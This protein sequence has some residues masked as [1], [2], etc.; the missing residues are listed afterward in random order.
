VGTGRF[1]AIWLAA[2]AMLWGAGE[3]AGARACAGC[4][5]EQ[6][7]KQARSRHARALRPIL[8]TR[9]PELFR[10][11]GETGGTALKYRPVETGVL[12]TA[13][14]GGE[15]AAALL[16]WAFGAGAQGFTPVGRAGKIYFEH[17][18][19]YYTAPGRRAL[20]LGH[21]TEP[22]PSA[23]AALGMIQTPETIYRCFNCHATG[24][25]R[26]SDRP[27]LSSMQPGVGCERCH[28]PGGEHIAAVRAG[29][30]AQIFRTL[31]NPGRFPARAVVEI[32][33]E[34]HRL[35][36]PGG[37][38]AAPEAEDPVSVRFAPI[39]FSQSKCFRAGKNFSCL[40]CHD[41]HADARRD[42]SFYTSKCLG[43]HGDAPASSACRRA[44][45]QDCLPCHMRRSSPAPYLTFTDHRI[46]V[47]QAAAGDGS[48][49]AVEKLLASEE[50]TKALEALKTIPASN[51]RWHLLASKAFDG[52]RERGR[53]VAEAR[54]A[55]EMDGASE[56]HH[57]QLGQLLLSYGAPQQA[58]EVLSSA[59]RLFPDS[60]LIRLGK[61]LALKEL[62]RYEEAEKELLECLRR[63]PNLGVALDALATVY[64][65][66][67]RYEETRQAAERFL[68]DNPVDFRG[69]YYLAAARDGLKLEA[70]ETE[71]LLREAIAIKPDFAASH[72][73]LGKILL[74]SG[75]PAEAAPVLE[76]AVR[77]RPDYAPSHYYLATA[78]RRLG[79][80]D[81]AA[82]EFQAV[83]DL[84]RKERESAPLLVRPQK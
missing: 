50:Y 59:Q 84:N 69:Y 9:M 8:E 24:V 53:A 73:L 13:R 19:S 43:C 21:P 58:Y 67:K 57:L 46:R 79:R 32:C 72:A 7:E 20:T 23:A 5:R 71:K 52:L 40:T 22:P 64:I 54:Q 80:N 18:I 68:R 26:G 38:S 35:G 11:P 62:D 34:C 56:S 36:E 4:H 29:R 65:H 49:A 16:E 48:L 76:E 2:P 81:A 75:K 1:L 3:F 33:A 63:R 51:A 37:G 42:D 30:R 47:Y 39:G 70:A 61:G 6:Y 78:Y 77:L 14:R 45:K 66:T 74:E 83:S 82:R 31:L 12:V 15:R 25:K 10:G 41:P 27:D 60:L 17:R 55:L 44:V 28:G